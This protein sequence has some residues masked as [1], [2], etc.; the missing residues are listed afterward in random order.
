MLNTFTPT[1]VDHETGARLM[2]AIAG[3]ANRPNPYPLYQTQRERPVWRD[4]AGAYVFGRHRDVASLIQDP[5][6]SSD[7]ANSA[8]GGAARSFLN[9]DPPEHDRLR[10]MTMRHFG[11]PGNAL[12]LQRMTP[13][14]KAMMC[15]LIDRLTDRSEVDVV[16]E[17]SYPFPRGVM[18]DLLGVPREDEPKFCAWA[19]AIA[20]AT[21]RDSGY[22]SKEAER[23][24]QELA[25]YVVGLVN[26]RRRSPGDDLLCCMVSD[27][28]D[29]ALR[30]E[31]VRV[32]LLL[33]LAG[34]RT[35]ANLISN[36]VLTLLRFPHVFERLRKEP[37]LA[38]ALVEELL[39]YEPPVHIILPG[40]V[41]YRRRRGS[42]SRWI[43][44]ATYPCIRQS[45]SDAFRQSRH[46]QSRST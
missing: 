23:L 9:M 46:L 33:L 24:F 29:G 16:A 25:G 42:R 30:S 40:T 7:S 28:H 45:G 14:L 38:P 26:K 31:I 27:A 20:H 37:G 12:R 11:P 10:R 13:A 21:D 15:T 19:E 22:R 8:Q 17:I 43:T 2:T 1:G 39:R 35:T 18:A 6:L 41:R 5:R 36:G 34:H 4:S 32:A 44:R 3:P